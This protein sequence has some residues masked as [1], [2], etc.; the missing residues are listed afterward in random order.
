MTTEPYKQRVI[1][2][3]TE[4]N[5]KLVALTQF[6]NSSAVFRALEA[7]DQVL[8]LQQRDSMVSY[9][10]ILDLRLARFLNRV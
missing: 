3:R 8:L 6:I 7:V 10:S 9:L 1:D 5:T 4:L 2:E